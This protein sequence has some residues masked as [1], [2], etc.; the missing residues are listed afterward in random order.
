MKLRLQVILDGYIVLQM[1]QNIKNPSGF[2]LMQTIV[3]LDCSIAILAHRKTKEAV[4]RWVR[5]TT[6]TTNK[7]RT[8]LRILC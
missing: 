7:Q 1:K 5:Q 3:L 2:S 4:T 8:R 6:N